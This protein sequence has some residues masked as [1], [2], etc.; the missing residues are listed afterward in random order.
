MVLFP[1]LQWHPCHPQAGVIALVAMALLSSSM[2]RHPC[3]HHN[4][5]VALI[6]MVLLL[7]MHRHLCCHCNGDCHSHYNGVSALVELA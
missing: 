7:L 3:H 1:L 2:H 5:V 4:G 6:M